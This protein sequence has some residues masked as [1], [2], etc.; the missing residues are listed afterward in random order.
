MMVV[1]C[2][3]YDDIVVLYSPY[4]Y[5]IMSINLFSYDFF[6]S[7]A[8]AW[9]ALIWGFVCGF[10]YRQILRKLFPHTIRGKGKN[11]IYHGRMM[12][13]IV[14]WLLII[15]AVLTTWSPVLFFC[16][17]FCFFEAIFSRCGFY[18]LIGKSSCPLE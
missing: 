12:R 11:I 7:I 4:S 6:I 17:G 16:A 18:A 13:A 9:W 8:I 10:V 3:A 2:C 5:S 1:Y 15:W 14:W